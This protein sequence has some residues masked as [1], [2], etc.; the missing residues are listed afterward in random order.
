MSVRVLL[1]DAAWA[2][3]APL[4]ATLTSRAG[5]PPALS[6]RLFRE[7]G[8]SRARPGTP[9]RAL[10][11]DCGHWDAVSNR[12]RRWEARGL[13]RRLWERLQA[14]A[15]PLTR[16][17]CIDAPL[18]R[19][20]PHAAGAW[21]KTAAPPPRLWAALGVASPP[22]AMPAVVMHAAAARSSSR[23]GPVLR[24]PSWRRSGRR[25]LPRP[26]CP[27]REGTRGLTAIASA[28]N[29][30]PRTWC[31]CYRPRAIGPSLSTMSPTSTSDASRGSGSSITSN[32][33]A[34][35]P[36]GRSNCV[37]PLWR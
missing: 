27:L 13:W 32:S 15:W 12:L 35:W 4:R 28:C 3:L 20:H 11:A 24:V 25:G 29:S 22:Q 21:K 5:S 10:P 16:P 26:R 1:T 17:L 9:W 14:A 2:A 33:F 31:Q 23:P 37:S 30:W 36:P 6:D 8:R 18:V 7:A 34:A 19:A